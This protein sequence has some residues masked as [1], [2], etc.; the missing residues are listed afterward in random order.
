MLAAILFPDLHRWHSQILQKIFL[1]GILNKADCIIANSDHTAKDIC[2]VYPKNCKKVKRIYLGA[3][4]IYKPTLKSDVLDKYTIAAPYFLFVG[5]IE[6]RKNLLTLLESFRLFKERNKNGVKL[7]IAGGVGWKSE[8]FFQAL[9]SHP[10]KEE[11]IV[12]GF[13]NKSDLPALYT[14]AIA[15]IYPSLYEGFG[16]PV[17][18]AMNCGTPVIAANNSSLPEAGGKVASY[19]ETNNPEDLSAKMTHHATN[20]GLREQQKVDMQAHVKNFDWDKF[21]AEFWKALSEL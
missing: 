16:L 21:A 5:T 19:F 20:T 12:T 6:P 17:L 13:A 10:F 18:E 3:N 9:K 15:L 14:N 2:E 1:K 11:I 7:V 4:S 8:T